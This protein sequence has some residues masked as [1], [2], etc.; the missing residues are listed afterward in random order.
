MAKRKRV[1]ASQT[2]IGN[3]QRTPTVDQHILRFNVSVDKASSVEVVQSAQK[4]K[5]DL[6]EL[7]QRKTISEA[8]CV[9]L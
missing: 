4:L 2:E 3:L 9:G 5:Y 8:I 6:F 1:A 7:F